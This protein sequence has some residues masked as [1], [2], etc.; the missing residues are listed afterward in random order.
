MK[1]IILI[2]SILTALYG[3]FWAFIIPDYIKANDYLKNA[4][5]VDMA[6]DKDIICD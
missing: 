6:S 4:C 3:L 2:L 5:M 1:K